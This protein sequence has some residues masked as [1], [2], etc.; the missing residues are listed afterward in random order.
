MNLAMK[1]AMDYIDEQ[2]ITAFYSGNAKDYGDYVLGIL[3]NV[4]FEL[5]ECFPNVTQRYPCISS[6]YHLQLVKRLIPLFLL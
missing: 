6:V 1:I 3:S 4:I 2:F 5:G